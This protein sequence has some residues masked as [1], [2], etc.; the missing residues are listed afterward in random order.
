MATRVMIDPARIEP[1]KI[2]QAV[3]VL[4]DGGLIAYPTDTVY[5]LGCA[6][7]AR[8]AVERL[9][10]AKRMDTRK[11]LALICPDVST[12]ATYASF[13]DEAYRLAKSI[14]P[15]PYTLVL[16]ATREVPRTLMDKK[17]R[18]VGIRIPDHPVVT[19]LVKA[20]G[21]PLLTTSAVPPEGEGACRDADE[22]DEAFGRQIDLVID[23]GETSGALSTVLALT[24]G[25]V[26]VVREGAGPVGHLLEG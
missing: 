3:D 21:R 1:R 17:R 14:F 6:L 18:Q 5:A 15:G 19:A 4:H 2:A 9:Y 23:G 24:D 12:A 22:V 10:R 13:S 26:E 20:L 7:E 25:A 16:P 8:R 11:R